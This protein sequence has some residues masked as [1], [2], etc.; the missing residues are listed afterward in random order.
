VH[1]VGFII[2]NFAIMFEWYLTGSE[3]TVWWFTL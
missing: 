2:T 1:L 3:M